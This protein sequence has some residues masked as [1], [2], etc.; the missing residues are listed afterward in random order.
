MLDNSMPTGIEDVPSLSAAM[1]GNATLARRFVAMLLDKST[2]EVSEN[3]FLTF[4]DD[5]DPIDRSTL[6]VDV[7]AAAVLLASQ[8]ESTPQLL[9]ALRRET[10][11]V[12]IRL[13]DETLQ[14]PLEEVIRMCLIGRSTKL[15]AMHQLD[16]LRTSQRRLERRSAVILTCETDRRS[17]SRMAARGLTAMALDVPIIALA[18]NAAVSIPESLR[19]LADRTITFGPFDAKGLEVLIHAVTGEVV[20]V[21]DAAWIAAITHDDL[22]MSVSLNRGGEASL[23]KLQTVVEVRKTRAIDAPLV[24]D[25]SGY[26]HAKEVALG[27]IADLEAYRAGTIPWSAVDRGLVLAG[28]PGTGKTFFAGA[29]AR[30]AGLPLHVGSLAT[31]QSKGHLGDTLGAMKKTFAAARADAPSVIF[32]DELDSF[33]D[34]VAFQ[35]HHRDYSSQVVNCLLEELDGAQDRTGV[36][37]L[38]ATNLVE[39]IDPAILRP[40]RLDRVVRIELPDADGLVGIMRSLLGR[41]LDGVDLMPVALAGRGGSGADAS[42]WVRRARGIARRAERGLELRDLLAAA[43]EGREQM[44]PEARWRA[45]VHEAGHACAA[46]ALGIGRALEIILHDGGG[47]TSILHTKEGMTQETGTGMIVQILAGREAERLILGEV[48]AGAGGTPTSDLAL[49]TKTA[50]SMEA[51]WGLGRLGPIFLQ[52]Q[53]TPHASVPD[54]VFASVV[55]LLHHAEREAARLVAANEEAIR[56]CAKEVEAAGCLDEVAILESFGDLP[57]FTLQAQRRKD[58]VAA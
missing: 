10:P 51:S 11:I 1:P 42:A 37:V 12:V 48:S 47:T 57:P 21:D 53:N 6:S 22:R 45:A 29:F 8:L 52:S 50:L 16:E 43:G 58:D 15:I 44:S 20:V 32:I 19:A 33:G 24:Q 26:G 13:P 54:V 39:R 17:L 7:A 36:V 23:R 18:T 41:E 2:K 35:D 30:T 9:K 49:A 55:H 4:D 46:V 38:G 27:M 28:P 5:D 14:D 3:A 31:W 40:G 56:R 25:L 34:R